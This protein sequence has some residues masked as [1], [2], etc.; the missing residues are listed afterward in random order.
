MKW[1]AKNAEF[2]RSLRAKQIPCGII[3]RLDVRRADANRKQMSILRDS[4][5]KQQFVSMPDGRHKHGFLFS[6]LFLREESECD[7]NRPLNRE[8]GKLN[9]SSRPNNATGLGRTEEMLRNKASSL[10]L[11]LKDIKEMVPFTPLSPPSCV[12]FD[13]NLTSFLERGTRLVITV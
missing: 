8:A 13:N 6:H 1:R 9:K 12:S 2:L 3:N 7:K 4:K 10:L 11:F 5:K